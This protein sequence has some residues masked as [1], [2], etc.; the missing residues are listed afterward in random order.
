MAILFPVVLML[1]LLVVQAGLWWYA[2]QTALTAAREGS[3]AARMYGATPAA[4]AARARSVLDRLSTGLSDKQVSTAGSDGQDVRISVSVR[5]V[6]LVP[7][8]PGKKLTQQVVAPVE[9]WT[10]PG[11]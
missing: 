7:G 10:V 6:S 1:V 2:R 5:A 9:R 8:V 11:Q 3:E 4:G